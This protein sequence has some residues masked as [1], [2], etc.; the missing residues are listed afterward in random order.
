MYQISACI[1]EDG[2]SDEVIGLVS[3][4]RSIGLEI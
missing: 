3:Q 4:V 2:S 1:C